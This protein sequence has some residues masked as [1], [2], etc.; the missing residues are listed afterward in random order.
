M[1]KKEIIDSFK[2]NE[3]DVGSSQVQIALLTSKILHLSGHSKVHKKDKHS[4]RGLIMA[5][6]NRKKLLAYLKRK[7]ES[8]YK[9]I[10]AKLGLRK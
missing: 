5:I 3:K 10:I 8:Q 9:E 4:N 2:I 1:I 6:S 7:N